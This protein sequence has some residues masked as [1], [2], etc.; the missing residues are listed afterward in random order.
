VQIREGYRVGRGAA[1]GRGALVGCRDRQSYSHV[2]FV[3]KIYIMQ[4]IKWLNGN[5]LCFK[6]M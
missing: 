5:N 3:S 1:K 2:A 6:D 4:Y